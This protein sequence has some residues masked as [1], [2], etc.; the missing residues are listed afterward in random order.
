M[1]VFSKI[2]AA[3][4]FVLGGILLVLGTIGVFTGSAANF[5]L[6]PI[7][8][9]IPALVGWG[10]VR[11]VYLAWKIKPPAP[12]GFCAQCGYDLTGNTSGICPECGTPTGGLPS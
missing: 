9:G 10:I 12:A 11:S 7:A 8:G 3:L 1:S 4:A 2:C 6:P 5:K